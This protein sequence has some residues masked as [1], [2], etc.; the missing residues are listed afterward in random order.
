MTDTTTAPDEVAAAD[1]P[2]TPSRGNRFVAWLRNRDKAELIVWVVLVAIALFLRLYHLG[3]RPFHHDESQDAYFSFTFSKD[4]GSYEYNPLLHGP[5]RFYMTAL[6]YKL[7]GDSDFTARLA[8]ALMGTL[9]VALPY[10]LRRQLGRVAAIGAGVI[11][12][13]SPSILYFSR[14]AREDIYLAA[15][16][17]AFAV[18]AFRFIRRPH[19]LTLSL[20]GALVSVAF[21]VKESGLVMVAIAG[22]FFLVAIATQGALARQRGTPVGDGEI[23]SAARAVGW[24]G[25]VYAIST[26]LV[27][28]AALFTVFFTHSHCTTT[29]YAGHAAQPANCLEGVVYGMKYWMAQQPVARGADKAWL[30]PVII[31]GNEWPALLLALVGAA[32]AFLRPTTLRLFLVWMFVGELAFYCWGKERFAWLV[33]H[34]LVPMILL[35]GVGLQSLWELRSRVARTAAL[36]AV[37]IG[38]V[39]MV[40]ASYSANARQGA[41]PR[42]LLVS[43]QSSTQVKQVAEEVQALNR[44]AK[45]AGMPELTITIDSSQGATFPYAWYFRHDQVGYI[46]MTQA[47][48][49]PNTQVLIMTE[50]AK[51]AQQPNLSAYAGR[52]FDFRVW[53]VKDYAKKFSAHAWWNWLTKRQPWNPTGG[54]KEW[55]FLR[56][57]AG[58]LPGRGTKTQIP[59]PPT[60]S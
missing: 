3:D 57:D 52:R 7:F 34:P 22:L 15:V 17:L 41:N 59:A 9:L 2:A 49:T 16:S 24:S 1:A 45:A 11:L 14:F 56:R 60:V 23:L 19:A 47:N 38:A 12:A 5:M 55:F 54:M 37:A 36:V 31:V 20:L 39:Y 44:K 42:N 10:L 51:T 53:W 27:V 26:M 18:T 40:G 28:Y 46:D 4:F 30:Y 29:A 48:Y 8:P 6:I 58:E 21:A 32:F 25:W 50:E 35:A 33:I 13:V 43:T